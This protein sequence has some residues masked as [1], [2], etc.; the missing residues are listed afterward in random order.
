MSS[1]D[2]VGRDD[3]GQRYE[4]ILLLSELPFSSYLHSTRELIARD[5]HRQDSESR[6]SND[7]CL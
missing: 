7:W 4:E 3:S 5:V 6:L 1:T 2:S